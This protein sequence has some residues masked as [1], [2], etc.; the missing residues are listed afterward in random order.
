MRQDF[1]R[2]VFARLPLAQAVLLLWQ[3]VC[4]DDSLA[5]LFDRHRGR[6]YVKKITFPLMAQLVRDALMEPDGSGHKAFC[7]A[8]E[9]GLLPAVLSSTYD[10]LA[11][12]PLAVR[13]AFLADDA[14]CLRQ[15]FP[16]TEL[17]DPVPASLRD[18]EVILLDGKVVKR[19]PRRLQPPRQRKPPARKEGKRD[20]TSVHR[21][22]NAHRQASRKATVT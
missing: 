3:Y 6:H 13:E 5:D 8:Q 21:L 7:R 22:L 16:D 4:D 19:V 2:E 10:K 17:T 11:P 1:E 12:L 20:H 18:F 9:G 15:V 14:R